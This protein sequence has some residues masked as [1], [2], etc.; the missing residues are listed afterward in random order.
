MRATELKG[1]LRAVLEEMKALADGAERE[2]RDFSAEERDLVKGKLAEAQDLK[3]KI[4]EAEGNEAIRRE[5]EALGAGLR[6]QWADDGRAGARPGRGKSIGEQFVQSEAFRAWMKQVAPGGR[7]P[8]AMKGLTSPPVEFKTLLTGGS[9]TS[10]G[11]FIEADRTDIY[12]PLGRR[13]LTL[14]D[15]VAVRQTTSDLVEF[16]RQTAQVTQATPVA[17][18][19]ATSGSTGTKPEGTMAFEIVQ[20][21]VKTIA[22][23]IPATKAALSDAAQLRS[24]IDQELRE[25]LEEDLEDEIV[26]GA[27]GSHFTGLLNTEGVLGQAWDTDML[28]TIRKART[29]LRVTGK[30]R[31]TAMLLHPNDAEAL[32]LLEDDQGRYYFGGPEEGGVQRAWRVPV[33]E[34]EAMTEG[35]GLMGDFRKAVI[36]DRERANISVSDSHADFFVRNMVAVLAEMRAAFGVV[37]PSAFIIVDLALGS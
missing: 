27:G 1:R 13:P 11:A 10:A 29:A 3:A 16:V 37:R 30:S 28:T 15:L 23:W 31:P 2:A 7:I 33:V 12:E 25:D 8:D 6:E 36:W 9:D 22:V 26:G 20:T 35:A 19:T 24:L 32:D 5:I 21:P 17:E 14:R 34:S 4:A 18:A